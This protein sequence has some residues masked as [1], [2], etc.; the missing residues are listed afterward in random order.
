MLESPGAGYSGAVALRSGKRLSD[1]STCD[2]R[3]APKRRKVRGP[4]ATRAKE[5]ELTPT[6]V[7]FPFATH[8]V[9][10]TTPRG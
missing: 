1:P 2:Y 10:A 3:S 8:N 7:P 6:P 5:Y 9:P 4:P